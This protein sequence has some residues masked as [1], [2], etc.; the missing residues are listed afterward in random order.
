MTRSQL[1]S[2]TSI[3]IAPP[4]ATKT[5]GTATPAPNNN[6]R[7]PAAAI[8]RRAGCSRSP[9]KSGGSSDRKDAPDNGDDD[10]SD[11]L[12]DDPEG[13]SHDAL[14]KDERFLTSRAVRARYGNCSDMWIYRRLHDAS[15]FP[16]PIE[17]TGRRF[18]KLS[19]LIAWERA[20]AKAPGQRATKA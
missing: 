14:A 17:I 4:V 10:S 1:L 19:A 3:L 6:S 13:P 11:G 15:G 9:R 18:W 2:G 16:W 5:P 20:R 8:C 7:S 12:D